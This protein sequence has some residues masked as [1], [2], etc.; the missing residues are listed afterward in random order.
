MVASA[1]IFTVAD[2]A[3]VAG[4]EPIALYRAAARGYLSIRRAPGGQERIVDADLQSWLMSH[5][6]DVPMPPHDNDWFTGE[7][8]LRFLE[9]QVLKAIEKQIPEDFVKQPEIARQYAKDRAKIVPQRAT[10][11]DPRRLLQAKPSQLIGLNGEKY[12]ERYGT[13]AHAWSVYRLRLEAARLLAS[14]KGLSFD[15]LKAGKL[16]RLYQPE[17]YE[18]VRAAYAELVRRSVVRVSRNVTVSDPLTQGDAVVTVQITLG[19]DAALLPLVDAVMR[20][21]F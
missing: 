8:E 19:V 6:Q 15:D 5:K 10:Y 12:D 18:A 7:N 4:V 1:S 3:A 17:N 13:V 14:P 16:R 9:Q 11:N 21:A 20:L 2:A